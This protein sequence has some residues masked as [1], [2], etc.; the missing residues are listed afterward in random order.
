MPSVSCPFILCGFL[1]TNCFPSLFFFS[2]FFF[3]KCV[4]RAGICQVHLEVSL[5]P[6]HV[7]FSGMQISH[8]LSFSLNERHSPLKQKELVILISQE[9]LALH[10]DR[11]VPLGMKGIVHIPLGF[12][13]DFLGKAKLISASFMPHAQYYI[14]CLWEAS[15]SCIVCVTSNCYLS[16]T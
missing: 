2:F 12:G 7:L 10:G 13:W 9:A 8:S 1:G 5:W 16:M 6:I 14:S 11:N 3:L 4:M 15:C